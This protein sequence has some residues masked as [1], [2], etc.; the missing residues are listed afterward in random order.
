MSRVTDDSKDADSARATEL[1]P[2][3]LVV[4][5][6]VRPQ[7]RKGELLAELLTEFPERFANAPRVYLA[8]P[9]FQG[10][11]DRARAATVTSFWLP[12]GKQVGRIV[13]GLDL[14]QSISDAEQL[15][16]NDVLVPL[17]ERRSLDEDAVYIHDLIGCRLFDRSD[18]VGVVEDVLSISET[19]AV[20]EAL[21]VA[22]V[23]V[24]TGADQTEYLVP[25]ARAFLRSI[26]VAQRRVEMELPEALLDVYRQKGPAQN[27]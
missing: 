3:W 22:P 8:T 23:L 21:E 12:Q 24:V 2:K 16:G 18:L 25:F 11:A 10:D 26:D 7:G 27:R 6:L 19:S 9:G 15:A 5:H 20:S 1:P 4:A 13:L 14:S 17:S